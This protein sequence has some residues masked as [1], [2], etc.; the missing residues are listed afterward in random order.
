[1]LDEGGENAA[2][3]CEAD[4]A[5]VFRINGDVLR[6]VAIYGRVPAVPNPISRGST[7]GRAAIDRRTIHIPDLTAVSKKSFL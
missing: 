5:A 7:I 2:R 3:L 1:M 4:D 6:P